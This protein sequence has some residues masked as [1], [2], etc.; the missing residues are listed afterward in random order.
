MSVII[1]QN[2]ICYYIIYDYKNQRVL[3]EKGDNGII[4]PCLCLPHQEIAFFPSYIPLIIGTIK[5]VYGLDVIVLRHLDATEVNV[6]YCE[7]ELIDGKVLE[8]NSHKWYEVEHLVSVLWEENYQ[9]EFLMS[10]WNLKDTKTCKFSY[11]NWE[12]NGWYEETTQHIKSLFLKD[13]IEV[14]QIEQVKGAWGWSSILKIYTDNCIKYYKKNYLKP[15]SEISIIRLLSEKWHNNLPTII[16]GDAIDDWFIMDDFGGEP[17]EIMNNAEKH[18]AI[19]LYADMQIYSY[20]ILEQFKEIG[21]LNLTLPNI[22]M[23]FKDMLGHFKNWMSEEQLNSDMM[24]EWLQNEIGTLSDISTIPYTLHNEDFR[25]GNIV[26]SENN[27]V[28]YDWK[29]VVISH[30]FFSIQYFFRR[31][32]LEKNSYLEQNLLITYLEQWHEFGSMR[33]LYKVYGTIELLSE[34][35]NVVRCFLDLKY[36]NKSTQWY[37][38]THTHIMQCIKN[39]CAAVEKENNRNE[40]SLKCV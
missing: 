2:N 40:E 11:S 24:V 29:N 6:H 30:P 5:K 12:Y 20:K 39:I 25:E 21:C 31:L 17:L 8:S 32:N 9:K 38:N 22:L 23:Y 34:V 35:Y 4:I 28:I 14:T 1:N 27:I 37:K 16:Y 10:W 15:P 26:V 18:K 7:V 19:K 33:Q 36:L 13:N 3:L